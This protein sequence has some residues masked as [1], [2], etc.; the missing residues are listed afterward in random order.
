MIDFPQKPSSSWFPQEEYNDRPKQYE[1]AI[2]AASYWFVQ[3]T[4]I[5]R[6]RPLF[7]Y[8]WQVCLFVYLPS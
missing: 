3:E 4:V 5:V 1:S 7:N 2:Y 8:L 6:G